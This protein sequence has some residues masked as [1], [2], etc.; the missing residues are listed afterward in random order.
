MSLPFLHSPAKI[1]AE[2]LITLES[3]TSPDFP[4]DPW[5][6]YVDTEPSDPDNCITL[7]DTQPQD[8]GRAMFDGEDFDHLGITVRIRGTDKPTCLAKA[9]AIKNTMA[10]TVYR[11]T[12]TL[13]AASYLVQCVSKFKLVSVG[14]DSPKTKR[15]VYNINCMVS[16]ERES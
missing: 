9:D 15:S 1:V 14:K 3:G 7:F 13:D 4:N 2:L 8:D 10:E 12:V 16:I 6:I 5:P 11:N